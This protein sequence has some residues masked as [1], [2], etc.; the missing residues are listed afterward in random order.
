VAVSISTI[1][2]GTA[3]G[4]D[5][6]ESPFSGFGKINDNFAALKAA[7]DGFTSDGI[8][9]TE[10]DDDSLTFSGGSSLVL[11]ANL[12]LYGESHATQP[13]DIEFKYSG[14][15]SLSYDQTAGLWSFQ[16]NAVSNITTLTATT[17]YGPSAS[18]RMVLL[19]SSTGGSA[20][21]DLY[22]PSHATQPYD[23]EFQANSAVRLHYDHSTSTWDFQSNNVTLGGTLTMDTGV[24]VA[25]LPGT[26]AVGMI[27]H[28]TDADT[29][30]IGST[31][32]G[33]AAAAAMVWYN[34]SDWTVIG[35]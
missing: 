20:E 21:M 14:T 16:N 33:G 34:G 15:L 1:N 11:G 27:A 12:T 31:V 9:H 29:P 3:A 26:P 23:I 13:Y 22:G 25:G 6:G 4:D 19:A 7:I 10:A 17:Y 28:V 5:T 32:V 2:R 8:Y 35:V 30:V 24:T 18:G